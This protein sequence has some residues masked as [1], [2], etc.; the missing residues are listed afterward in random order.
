MNVTL[1]PVHMV[2]QLWPRLA[3]G[4]HEAVM[5]TGGDITAGDLWT[6]CR[7]GYGLLFVAHDGEAISAASIWRFETWQSG[8]KLR[9]L[10]LYGS[11][12]NEWIGDMHAAVK[13]AAGRAD[14]VS[15][16]RVGWP[17]VFPNAKRL[18]VLYEEKAQ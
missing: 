9:C 5:A 6:T 17:K 11:S 18:R 16:G 7:A 13:A 10:A 2:D 3:E 12:M 4:F 14:L 8:A 15:E 1:V